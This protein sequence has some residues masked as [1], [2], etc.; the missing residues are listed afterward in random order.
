MVALGFIGVFASSAEL[1]VRQ[2][3][4]TKAQAVDEWRAD[5]GSAGMGYPNF[6]LR[7]G[8]KE[9]SGAGWII[10]ARPETLLV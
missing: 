1:R 4:W 6:D 9:V 7:A 2:R 5:R 3:D 10:A 8:L